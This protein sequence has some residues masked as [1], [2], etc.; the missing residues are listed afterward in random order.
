MPGH[1]LIERNMAKSFKAILSKAIVAAALTG[2]GTSHIDAILC[3]PQ[4]IESILPSIHEDT[5]IVSKAFTQSSGQSHLTCPETELLVSETESKLDN[6]SHPGVDKDL[7]LN[8]ECMTTSD[9]VEAQARD[10]KCQRDY[11]LI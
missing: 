2:H 10:K 1:E 5:P 11:L 7:Y 3:S 4:A 9:R 6:S 8:P